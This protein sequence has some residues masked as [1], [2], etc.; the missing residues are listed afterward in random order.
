[1]YEIIGTDNINLY[2]T[3]KSAYVSID[4]YYRQ[5]EVS[6]NTVMSYM[7]ETELIR[8]KILNYGKSCMNEEQ[9]A[10]M[11]NNIYRLIDVKTLDFVMLLPKS[12]LTYL[13]FDYAFNYNV[14]NLRD[15]CPNIIYVNFGAYF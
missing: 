7:D 3:C 2:K 13:T 1:M 11:F 4:I 9:K 5:H 8:H 14:D 12:N 15:I 6:C 10:Y